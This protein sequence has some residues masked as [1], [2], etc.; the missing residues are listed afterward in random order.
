M[1]EPIETLADAIKA[2]R[3]HC[4]LTQVDFAVA[5]NV[6]PASIHRWEAATSS[7]EFEMIVSLWSFAVQ[8]GSPTSRYFADFL[9]S[10]TDAIKPLFNAAQLPELKAIEKEI[11]ELD[12]AERQL[13]LALVN[14]LKRKSDETAIRGIRALLEPWSLPQNPAGHSKRDT[15]PSAPGSKSQAP[16]TKKR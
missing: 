8:R 14:L 9:V 11:A 15:S 6:A 5:L 7:P 16:R 12:V 2:L 10:R 3:K 4:S 1:S 13:V